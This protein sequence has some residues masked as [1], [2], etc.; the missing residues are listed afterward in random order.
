M[1][2]FF[3]VIL[4]M[5]AYGCNVLP[6]SFSKLTEE[7]QA[8]TPSTP[9]DPCSGAVE[10]AKL[11]IEFAAY[12]ANCSFNDGSNRAPAAGFWQARHEQKIT[13]GLP[14]HSKLCNA[15]ISSTSTKTMYADALVLLWDKYVLFS[16]EKL[17]VESRLDSEAGTGL[18]WNWEKV[19]GAAL[20][21]A[22]EPYCIEAGDE[23]CD[24][25]K[26]NEYESVSVNLNPASLKAILKKQ[27]SMTSTSF[28]L[29]TAGDGADWEALQ[30][31]SLT[32]CY[33][34]KLN[35]ELTVAYVPAS[36]TVIPEDSFTPAP[37]TDPLIPA[38]ASEG[39]PSAQ[40]SATGP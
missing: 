15:K 25:P 10:E 20:K 33:H 7:N 8:A 24:L 29:I 38:P 31:S 14:P 35:L 19:R 36:S 11:P 5:S 3:V 30:D 18:I 6:S 27:E 21:G 9:L 4:A 16:S 32:D 39:T 2:I 37:T 17:A 13:V 26:A 1:R 22:D 28:A 34:R 12:S 23:H 40:P